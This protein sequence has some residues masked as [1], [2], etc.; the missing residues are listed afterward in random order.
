MERGLGGEEKTGAWLYN[1]VKY[2]GGK[3]R[4]F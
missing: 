4:K 1:M 3:Y 2:Y